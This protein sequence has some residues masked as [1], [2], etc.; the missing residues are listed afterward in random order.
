[1]L[2][3]G[4]NLLRS[5]AVIVV[6]AGLLPVMGLVPRACADEEPIGYAW[7]K[8]GEAVDPAFG[9]FAIGDGRLIASSFG[10]SFLVDTQEQTTQ[11]FGYFVVSV[12]KVG[13]GDF[14][15]V[16][17]D[18]NDGLCYI[19]RCT[20]GVVSDRMI[21]EVDFGGWIS[22]AGEGND[23]YAFGFGSKLMHFDIN[24]GSWS[25]IPADLPAAF[26]YAGQCT[27][28]YLYL[29]YG[30]VSDNS[31]ALYRYD[32][33][34]HNWLDLSPDTSELIGFSGVPIHNMWVSGD[35]ALIS[36][37]LDFNYHKVYSYKNGQWAHDFDTTGVYNYGTCVNNNPLIGSGILITNSAYY[38]FN[39]G[40][41]WVDLEKPAD[42]INPNNNW[43][44]SYICSDSDGSIYTWVGENS[45]LSNI[46]KLVSAVAADETPPVITT[47][48]AD[49]TVSSSTYT[50]T[51]KAEDEVDGVVTPTVKLGGESGTVL[52]GSAQGDGSYS[53]T[54]ELAEGD[55]T[56]YIEATDE[57]DNKSNATCT[58][59][60]T[61]AA[62]DTTPPAFDSGYPAIDN[63]TATGF[64][65]AVKLDEPG[66][67]YYKVVADGDDPGIGYE[68]WTFIEITGTETVTAGV[69]G[70]TPETAYDV[71]V[72][73]KDTAGNWQAAP[74]KLDITTTRGSD[75]T[76]FSIERVGSGGF[77]HGQVA[78]ITVQMTNNAGASQQATLILCLYNNTSKSME[79]YA[80]ASGEVASGAQVEMTTEGISIPAS[81]DY[82][83]RAFVWDSFEGMRPLLESPLQMTID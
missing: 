19:R 77:S 20:D 71:Y 72:I 48:A 10:T 28:S 82:S 21:R 18:L 1:M 16:E 76:G 43:L 2:Q 8:V 5:I 12:Q 30:A 46:Y 41:A 53:Y 57:S 80:C 63:I 56:I 58:V 44:Y 75:Q 33:T 32:R 38:Y 55:N 4:K 60:Y 37:C 9:L 36:I 27:S 50:F 35:D 31:A 54:A 73:A 23:I 42:I 74:V 78:S 39:S 59:T 34:K 79:N 29:A 17:Y 26:F 65:L 61:A 68:S 67:S 66:V 11:D 62:G 25:E 14:F 70:L 52:T 51:V 3:R 64:D 6:L 22:L 83:V 13:D 7:E 81:G 45:S 40:S 69:S 49:G 15:F 24:T 47:S